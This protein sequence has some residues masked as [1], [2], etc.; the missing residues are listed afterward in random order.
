MRTKTVKHYFT[1]LQDKGCVW[2]VTTV[3]LLCLGWERKP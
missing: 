1:H 2:V 3:Y